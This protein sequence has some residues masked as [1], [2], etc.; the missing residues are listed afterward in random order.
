MELINLFWDKQKLKKLNSLCLHTLLNFNNKVNVFTYDPSLFKNFKHEN[1]SIYNANE[2]IEEKEKFYYKGKNTCISNCVVGFS[3]IFRYMLL[4]KVGGWYFDFDVIL[5]KE[6]PNNLISE[7]TIIRPH[8]TYRCASNVSKFQ[9][10][11][12]FLL[13]LYNITKFKVNDNNDEWALPLKIFE[14]SVFSKD[15]SK[16]IIDKKY[17]SDDNFSDVI[18]FLFTKS[19]NLNELTDNVGIHACHTYLSSGSWQPDLIYN[20]NNPPPLT[21]IHY[22]YRKY[23]I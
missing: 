16:Y 12:S 22:L 1:L 3:D 5:F 18:K 2:I 21:K 14:D 8:F 7:S 19:I 4:Y 10:N 20:F 17:F 6:I 15:Y 23:N 9:K 11:D 13:E